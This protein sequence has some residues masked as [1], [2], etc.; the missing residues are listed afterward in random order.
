MYLPHITTQHTQPPHQFQSSENHKYHHTMSNPNTSQ[1]SR[2][3]YSHPTPNSRN[4]TEINSERTR[5]VRFNPNVSSFH[6]QYTS[7]KLNTPQHFNKGNFHSTYINHTPNQP[8][9]R[10]QGRPA[11]LLESPTNTTRYISEDRETQHMASHIDRINNNRGRYQ[12]HFLV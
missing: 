9:N 5:Q 11:P 12:N 4:I 3:V 10:Y 6:P 2:Q 8:I 1:T 7:P